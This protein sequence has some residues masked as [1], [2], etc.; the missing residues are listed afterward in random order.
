MTA[1]VP[2]MKRIT[3]T[4]L[5]TVSL[6][7]IGYAEESKQIP[8]D[9]IW[10][11]NLPGTRDIA[12]I[13]L[14][15]T[16]P[17]PGVTGRTEAMFRREREQNIEQLR[18]ALAS[19][20]PTDRAQPSFV[21]PRAPDFYA[22]N[23]ASNRIANM[24]RPRFEGLEIKNGMFRAG[25]T[26]TLVF[27]HPA[28]YYLRLRKVERDANEITVHYEFVPHGSPEVTIHFALIP[29]GR[30]PAGEYQVRFKQIPLSQT[31]REAGFE[32]IASEAFEIVCRPFSFSMWEPTAVEDD[33][34]AKDA[35]LIPL[36]Q[37]W[38]YE[39][40]GTR[41][42]RELEPK[43]DVHDPSS[44]ELFYRSRVPKIARLLTSVPPKGAKAPPAFVVVGTGEEALKMAHAVLT[45]K[46][47]KDAG[48]SL[49]K[50]TEL[51]LVF[52]TFLFGWH[53]EIA[54]V[55][56]SPGL[57]KVK[58]QFIA[59]TEPSFG[60]KRFALIPIGKLS[61]GHVEVEIKE[62]P[63]VDYKGRPVMPKQDSERFVC[64]SFLFDVQ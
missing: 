26:M 13:P 55:E 47:R 34:P 9:Q 45:K 10:G 7:V 23:N 33:P 48:T 54:S 62:M 60:A 2:T 41:D 38:A 29:L 19:K 50:D 27:S 8:L 61:K 17:N 4:A 14:P 57:I 43:L 53:P 44:K 24:M 56:Q 11:Y 59:P 49:P 6:S 51:S 31:Y 28:S 64:G 16:D 20:P 58:Y 52:Y 3:L 63:P 30:L 42:I 21:I 5:L 12:G 37:I 18:R 40:P 46:E 25:E 39:M 32:P 1:R 22:L 15:Q 35:K 36:D